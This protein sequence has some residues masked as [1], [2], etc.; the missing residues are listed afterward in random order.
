[1]MHC[2]LLDDDVIQQP[3]FLWSYRLYRASD[4]WISLAVSTDK[5]S[6]NIF[7]VLERQE[8]WETGRFDTAAKRSVILTEWFNTIEEI[9]KDFTVDELLKRLRKADVPAAPVLSPEEV[10][11][12]PQVVAAGYIEESTHPLA[13][14][15]LSPRPAAHA[16]GEDLVLTPAPSHGQHGKQILEELGYSQETIS[17]LGD[18]GVVLMK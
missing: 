3:N 4:G 6:K 11:S 8:I 17:S 15:L 12:D 14:K 7:E 10:V 5:Q 16:F 13:G 9:V 1:M 2:S 18:D